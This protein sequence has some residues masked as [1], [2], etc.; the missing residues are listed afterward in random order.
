MAGHDDRGETLPLLSALPPFKN[1]NIVCTLGARGV[2][3]VT[4]DAGVRMTYVRA[5]EP[6]KGVKDTTGA[7]DC[8]T[9][10]FVQGL[11]RDKWEIEPVLRA[12][13]EAAGISVGVAGAMDSI[14]LVDR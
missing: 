10:Y 6:A 8:F 1:T 11:M 13:V 5:A 9:G 14:P 12:A 3:C 4:H 2:M 7:G